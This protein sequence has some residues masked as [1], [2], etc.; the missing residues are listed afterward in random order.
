VRLRVLELQRL[1]AAGVV[2]VAR[3]LSVGGLL[4]E[5]G[6]GEQLVGL[7]EQ[8][9]GHVRAE[10]QVEER[11]LAGGVVVQA[12]GALCSEK[13]GADGLD[14]ACLLVGPGG[15]EVGALG[16]GVE[17]AAVPGRHSL[18]ERVGEREGDWKLAAV[19]QREEDE[20]LEDQ[21]HLRQQR[22]LLRLA[23]LLALRAGRVRRLGLRRWRW[24][25]CDQPLGPGEGAVL[26]SRSRDRALVWP[27]DGERKELIVLLLLYVSP[28]ASRRDGCSL[29]GNLGLRIQAHATWPVGRDVG[30]PVARS[31]AGAT[32]VRAAVLSSAAAAGRGPGSITGD[33]RRNV[34]L[35]RLAGIDGEMSYHQCVVCLPRSRRVRSEH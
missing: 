19:N 28:L 1:D 25:R 35:A 15:V 12:G 24:Q 33:R 18:E 32:A 31:A 7:H 11:R 27:L 2:E 26:D 21:L 6:L 5:G 13:A 20:E 29:C 8:L 10:Q 4:R 34:G 23:S 17:G 3:E 16:E 22:P 9:C 30:R 14:L